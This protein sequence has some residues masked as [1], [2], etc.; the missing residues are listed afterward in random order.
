MNAG[1]FSVRNQRVI[2]VSMAL[3]LMG[4]LFAYKRLGRL[5]DPEFTIK[6]AL[7][8]T[9]Y[10]GASP[11]EVAKEVTNPIES[12]CQQ[13]GQLRRV[14]SESLR[15]RSVVT[16]VIQD[17]FHKDAI[18]QVWDEL[19]R[20]ID[21]VQPRLPP[22]VRGSSMVIDDFGDVYGIFLAITGKGFSQPEL[23]RYAE[24]LRRELI[25][26]PG[27]KKAE[28]F[29]EQQE[30]VYLEISRL[31]LASLGINEDQ[32]YRQLQAK[33]VASDG[34]R[35]RVGDKYIAV[36]PTGGF[37]S[38]EDML[39]LAIGS[40]NTGRQL[41]LKDVATLK[42]S[43]EDPPRRLLRYDG[44]PAIGL[45]ISTVQ[46]GNVVTM[47]QGIQR[48]LDDL[49]PNQPVGI[50][51]NEI[52]FQPT[53]VTKATNS[54]V[55]NLGKAV[56]IVFVVLL[57]AMGRRAGFI[58]GFVL[59]L[60]IM[61][62][63]LVMYLDGNLLMERI[64][65]GALIIALCMLTDN[66]IVVTEGI[67]VRI[68]SG[69]DKLP[70]IADVISQNQWPLFGATAIAVVAFAAIGLSEDRTG[71][72]C[73]SLFWVILI[74]LALSWVMA[75]T[76]TPLLC[77]LFFKPRPAGE[78]A[79]DPYAGWFFQGYRR[80]L[81]AA[82]RFR[83]A[84]LALTLLVFAIALRG[85]LSLD[86]SFFPPATRPQF[87]VDTFLPAGTDIRDTEAVAGNIERFIQALP[88]VTHISSFVGGGGLRFLLVYTPEKENPAYVQFLV[89]V[90][91]EKRIDGL[92]AT[93][94][95]ELDRN[96]PNANS[97]A[98]KFLLGP[99]SGGRVQVRFRG[100]D[101]AVLR[102]LAGQAQRVLEDDGEAKGVRTDWRQPEK[103]IR[104]DLLELQALRNGIT[105]VDVS[106]ALETG[107]EGR[108]VGFYR[109]PGSAE[110]GIYP[111]E[112]RLLP[113]VARPPP[114]ERSDAAMIRNMQIWSPKA[115]RMIPLRQV[116]SGVE[117][118]WEDPVVMRRDRSPTIT[119]HADPR[120]G[121]TSHLFDRVR[122]KIEE[123]ALPRGYSR[124]WGG[125]EEDSR[126][127]RAALAKPLPAALLLMVLIV[128]WL[129]NSIRSTL[130]ICLAVPLAIIG[131]TA[132]L[133]LT[134]QPFGFMA[135][136]GVIALGGEQ[137]KNSIVLVDEIYT[138]REGKAS[139]PAVVD[140]SVSRLRPVLLVAVTTVLGMIPLLQDPFF[141]AMAA[142]IMFGLAF[143]C[144]LTMI[145]VPVLYSIFFRVRPDVAPAP[146]AV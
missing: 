20:K 98:K 105:R 50:E 64:S 16:A 100:P 54:F 138:Q 132:G 28:L 83:W 23:R 46:G 79:P 47:G 4:G 118:Q 144:V 95:N 70:V 22:S 58:I 93:I 12:A 137:I 113:I 121:L 81:V 41:S 91:D 120:S 43:Y 107:F 87:M 84:V 40:D 76:V 62:T 78:A 146:E 25:L 39:N 59:V 24:F 30:V 66:A 73:N 38:A 74:S 34:G 15:G 145:V 18:P 77:Y 6:E 99:G 27:V 31:R 89:D 45:G 65:L 1:E 71:E 123:I 52:N 110:T 49:K 104:P 143:A 102:Q 35:V 114:A 72:Y 75:I 51:I 134:R 111:Q 57:I 116:V 131:V 126:D 61:G 69:E 33:N 92:I 130:V 124:E 56:T 96:Y 80:L 26:V 125:E 14:E 136:L 2:F 106:H 85:F 60:T 128:V 11:D 21:D 3:V 141:V 127:A 139:Y 44:Q 19:R 135:L 129:F 119:V 140:A 42:R 133:M 29:A 17:R 48:K 10:P 122:P 117:V 103:V 101:P 55:F 37:A 63:F 97:V 68:E 32:I 36:D 5:E 7:I 112:T 82:L 108:S 86:R 13:L 142:T 9:P 90:D 53:A 67:K 88:G 8:V 94:Q 115:S 109:E